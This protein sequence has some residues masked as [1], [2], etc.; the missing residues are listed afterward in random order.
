MFL[1]VS[2]FQELLQALSRAALCWHIV[3]REVV[4]Y[5][6]FSI[7]VTPLQAFVQDLSKCS[8]FSARDLF[9]P[10]VVD[11]VVQTR[12]SRYGLLFSSP[13]CASMSKQQ[14]FSEAMQIFAP[15]NYLALRNDSQVFEERYNREAKVVLDRERRVLKDEQS[16]KERRRDDQGDGQFMKQPRHD[17]NSRG[18]PGASGRG[19]GAGGGGRGTG[20]GGRGAAAPA[21]SNQPVGMCLAA[22]GLLL[23]VRDS[24]PCSFEAKGGCKFEHVRSIPRNISDA[25][26]DEWTQSISHAK[27][28]GF[29]D[30]VL[31]AIAD[32]P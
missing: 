24:K 13:S 16:K 10:Y 15:I 9:L 8:D 31:K 22:M 11:V 14:F 17:N 5:G 30:S 7:F 12:L 23:K 6:G 4:E 25:M 29:K 2:G 21:H 3:Y 19:R 27:P 28:S 32:L 20:G 1:G 18:A 26:R